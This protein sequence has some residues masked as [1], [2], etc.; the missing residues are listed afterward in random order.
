MKRERERERERERAGGLETG[1][2]GAI[3]RGRGVDEQGVYLFLCLWLARCFQNIQGSN[4]NEAL[5]Q[6]FDEFDKDHSGGISRNEL[7]EGLA[8]RYQLHYT[9]VD[10]DKVSCAFFPVCVACTVV[11]PLPY[12]VRHICR[13]C[14]SSIPTRAAT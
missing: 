10:Y 5:K 8:K 11:N 12:V 9:S 1:R 13:S 2:G 7:R 4:Q 3:K 6:M 14:G